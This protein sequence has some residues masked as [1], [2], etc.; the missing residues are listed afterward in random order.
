MQVLEPLCQHV[1]RLLR[2]EVVLVHAQAEQAVAYADQ[3]YSNYW[4]T[5]LL[6]R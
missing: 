1:G 5:H 3:K 2:Q 6:A 4:D